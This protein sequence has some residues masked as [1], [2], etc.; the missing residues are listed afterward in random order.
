M[1][2]DSASS[3]QPQQ[4]QLHQHNQQQPQQQS[5]KGQGVHTLAHHRSHTEGSRPV[6]GLVRYREEME[7]EGTLP[8]IVRCV[9]SSAEKV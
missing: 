3:K 1:P 8:G 4:Q 6:S 2:T 5:V 7:T 9:H